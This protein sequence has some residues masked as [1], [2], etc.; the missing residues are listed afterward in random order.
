MRKT[1]RERVRKAESDFRLAV[2]I[3]HSVEPFHNEQ[4]FHCQQSAEKYLKALLNE[5]GLV[6]PRT[7]TLKDLQSLLIPHYPNLNGLRRG[8]TFLTRLALK[9]GIQGTMPVSARR[10]RHCDGHNESAWSAA[11]FSD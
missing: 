11:P 10:N 4:C 9:H 6:I 3:A 2:S 8:L 7:H 1:T 5:L